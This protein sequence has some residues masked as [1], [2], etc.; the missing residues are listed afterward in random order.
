MLCDAKL[1]AQKRTRKTCVRYGD[2]LGHFSTLHSPTISLS[3]SPIGLGCWQLGA[4]WGAP[5]AEDTAADILAAYL[6]GVTTHAPGPLPQAF[7]DTADVYGDGRSERLIGDFLAERGREGITVATKFGRA[8]G[9]YPDGYTRDAL[10][11]AVDASRQR[12]RVDALDLLQLHCIP[13]AVLEDGAVF[14]WLRELRAEGR[15]RAFGASVETIAEGMLCLEQEG[16]ASLQIILNALRQRPLDELV[17]AAAARGV[18][19]VVRLPLASGLL[20]GRFT[21]ATTFPASDHRHYNRDGAAFNVGETFGGLPFPKGVALAETLEG[22]VLAKARQALDAPTLTL[23]QLSLLWL[24]CQPGV[25]TVIPGASTPQQARDNAAVMGM[26]T[27]PQ[28]LQ[29]AIRDFY[30]A[31]VDE[32]VRGPY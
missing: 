31:E 3:P 11:R 10:R 26:G 20:T 19:I 9:V 23:A 21:A 16:L 13:T 27:L 15:I 4:D 25:T 6:D 2:L 1:H 17:P 8:G 12:L 5:L 14:D 29:D 28:N 18:A 24:T 22:Q 32:H 30:R 7:V